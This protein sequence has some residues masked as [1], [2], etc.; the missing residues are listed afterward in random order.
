MRPVPRRVGLLAAALA[1]AAVVAAPAADAARLHPVMSGL[2]EP[3]YVTGHGGNLYVV[4]RRGVIRVRHGGRL[5]ARPFLDI[6]RHVT[7]AGGEQGLLSMA[8]APHFD[9]SHRVYVDFTNLNGDTRV[10]QYRTFPRNRNRVNPA[11]KRVLLKVGQPFDNHNGGQLQI[12]PDGLLY[13]SL[14]DGGSAGDPNLNGQSKGP[15]ATILRMDPTKR[16]PRAAMYAYGL[17]NPWRF[18][19]DKKTGGMWIGDVGQDTF[20]EVDHLRHD[21][22]RGTNFGWSF[23]EGRSVFKNQPIDRSRLRFPVAVYRHVVAGSD[24]CSVTG[25]Y[26][27]RGSAIPPLVGQYLYAD[28]CS[29]RIWKLPARGGRP[30]PTNM[31][32][33]AS[34]ISSFGQGSNGELYV[35][36]LGGTIFKMVP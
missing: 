5:L 4:L 28:F 6:S 10:V 23:Y 17:R 1:A 9:R 27:Y 31:S 14:G 12:G 26:V 20:E 15:L 7:T 34:S 3:T 22:P 30:K 2:G 13:I 25:G 24:N 36:S 11:T 21:T 32:F 29:G 35:V 16:H 33:K 18:S 19:F 8:F